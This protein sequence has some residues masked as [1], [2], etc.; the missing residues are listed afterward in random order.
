MKN[1]AALFLIVFLCLS[2]ISYNAS[3]DLYK[4]APDIVQ[5]TLPEML[6]PEY[7]I[8]AMDKPDEIILTLEQIMERN[9]EYLTKM[10]RPNPF[11]SIHPGRVPMDWQINRWPA[12]FIIPPDLE[13]MNSKDISNLTIK[14]IQAC[15]DYILAESYGNYLGVEYAEWELKALI[16]E[17]NIAAVNASLIPRPGIAVRTAR[18]RVVPALFP[19]VVGI[20][21]IDTSNYTVDL[22]TS[23]L[24]TIGRKVTVLHRS[25]SGSHLFVVGEN[26]YGWISA[27]DIAFGNNDSIRQY[28]NPD[29]FL[30][31]T[32]NRIPY[33]ADQECRYVSGWFRM[34][35]KIPIVSNSERHRVIVPV[36]M[37]NG[38]FMTETAFL[39]PDAD[40]HARYVPYT[41]RNIIMLAFKLL[42]D[43]YD[44]TGSALGRNHETTYR[45][46]FSC[47]GFVLP[48]N[49]GLFTFFGNKDIAA[50]PDMGKEKEY[51]L[52]LDNEPFVSF[53]VS[54]GHAML[55][56]GEHE[57][58]PVA[59]DQNGY[60]YVD[61]NGITMHVKRCSIITP[62]VVSYFLKYPITFLE[63]K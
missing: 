56:L 5:G 45:D 55:L 31:C 32:G 23:A 39:S 54:R 4:R 2:N 59:F 28:S 52:V 8:S 41:R 61:E 27:E 42:H 9:N 14:Q 26:Q 63:L 58:E 51:S 50:M 15:N 34:G 60:S 49:G 48:G 40:I 11:E 17:A 20:K 33:Y 30:V 47:F 57:G 7:W 18:L 10:S 22:W 29:K 35:D 3:G 6:N 12:R 1:N 36:R 16:D 38:E 37:V 44:W 21:N 43:P 25:K 62:R 13:S 53:A 19:S 46:I 24:V